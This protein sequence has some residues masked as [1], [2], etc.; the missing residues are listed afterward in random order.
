MPYFHYK[1]RDRKGAV[2]EGWME[3]RDRVTAGSMIS[4]PLAAGAETGDLPGAL[5][6]ISRQYQKQLNQSIQ[7]MTP[8]LEPLLILGVASSSAT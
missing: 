1:A 4:G 2:H 8:V 3:A 6:H 7:P 5:H